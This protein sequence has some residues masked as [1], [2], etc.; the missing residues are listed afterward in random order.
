[1]R[2]RM[3]TRAP[4]VVVLR[5][6][7]QSRLRARDHSGSASAFVST[8]KPVADLCWAWVGARL[9]AATSSEKLN[10]ARRGPVCEGL[11]I[12]TVSRPHRCGPQRAST[13][14]EVS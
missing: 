1:M 2:R 6:R 4:G 14:S 11:S 10:G 12:M 9:L 5:K 13:G 7:I 3:T 8:V